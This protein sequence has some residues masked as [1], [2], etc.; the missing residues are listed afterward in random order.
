MLPKLSKFANI[1]LKVYGAGVLSSGIYG[2]REEN[3]NLNK[4]IE[5]G[6]HPD[7]DTYAIRSFGGFTLGTFCGLFWPITL[8][9]RAVSLQLPTLETS[10][11]KDE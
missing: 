10:Q 5:N 7:V 3:I 2:L 8:L 6:Y 9:G 11:K 4:R 1:S